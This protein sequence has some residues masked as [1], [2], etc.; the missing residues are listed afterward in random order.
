MEEGKS[1]CSVG[2]GWGLGFRVS[3]ILGLG[4]GTGAICRQRG[5]YRADHR[6]C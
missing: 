3:L 2:P 6:G 1:G 4:G 5:V